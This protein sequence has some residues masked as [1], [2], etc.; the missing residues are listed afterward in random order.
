MPT[1]VLNGEAIEANIGD[2]LLTVARREA[3]HIGYFCDGRGLCPVCECRVISGAEHL[4]PVNKIEQRLLTPE[5]L[6]QGYRVACMMTVRSTGTIEMIARVEEMRRKAFGVIAPPAGTQRTDHL[7]SLVSDL[8]ELSVDQ[9][10]LVPA[11]LPIIVPQWRAKPAQIEGLV[12]YVTDA[13]R[14][15]QRNAFAEHDQSSPSQLPEQSSSDIT[16]SAQPS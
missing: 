12:A 7:S 13:L 2:N 15:I 8:V 3:S 6:A 14:M 11:S 10:R 9:V 1:V 5:Q 16:D 4:S